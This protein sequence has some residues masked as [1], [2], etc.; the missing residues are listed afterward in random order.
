MQITGC[1]KP[2]NTCPY[3][4]YYNAGIINA[5]LHALYPATRITFAY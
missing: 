5:V 1:G 2:F 4:N 3:V